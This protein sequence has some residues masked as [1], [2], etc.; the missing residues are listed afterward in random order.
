MLDIHMI[1]CSS[2]HLLT[3]KY[4][5]V[6][7]P[8]IS[9]LNHYFGLVG[10]PYPDIKPKYLYSQGPSLIEQVVV[11]AVTFTS[12][13]ALIILITTNPESIRNP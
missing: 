6:Y 2:E 7:K 8:C 9:V 11:L 10:F 1:I 13:V 12:L 4:Q 3:P 5:C